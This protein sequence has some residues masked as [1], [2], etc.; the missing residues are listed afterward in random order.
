[1]RKT[2]CP[3]AARYD[4]GE[5]GWPKCQC[6]DNGPTDEE[7]RAIIQRLANTIASGESNEAACY[8]AIASLNARMPL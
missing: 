5:C 2:W 1:M 7:A 6:P 8:A 4:R 3:D